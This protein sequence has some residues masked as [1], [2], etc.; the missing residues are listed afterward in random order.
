MGMG[1]LVEKNNKEKR[2]TP[3]DHYKTTK[4]KSTMS[5]T[6]APPEKCTHFLL[7]DFEREPP[8]KIC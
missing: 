5:H 3:Q 4:C 6:F 7:V 2:V 8:Q 1:T